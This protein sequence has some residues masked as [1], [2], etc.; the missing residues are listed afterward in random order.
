M[1]V[2]GLCTILVIMQRPSIVKIVNRGVEAP[3]K[4]RN[5]VHDDGA[6]YQ[7]LVLGCDAQH[8]Q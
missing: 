2:N 7:I 8:P 4:A 3:S 6:R 5:Y 1:N